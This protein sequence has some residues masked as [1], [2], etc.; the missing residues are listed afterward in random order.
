MS[1]DAYTVCK[2][3]G[4]ALPGNAETVNI[5]SSVVALNGKRMAQGAGLHRL[6]VDIKHDQTGTMKFYVSANRGVT[7]DQIYDSGVIAAPAATSSTIRDFAFEPYDD[8]KLD[9]LNGATPQTTFNV[10]VALTDER[11]PLT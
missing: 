3:I 2:Y 8:F 6:I 9:W 4:S 10:R 11:A 7:W 1:S 5:F